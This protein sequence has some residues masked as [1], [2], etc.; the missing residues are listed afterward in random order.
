MHRFSL[1]LAAL[2]VALPVSASA[3]QSWE[4]VSTQTALQALDYAPR[5]TVVPRAAFMRVP[6]IPD[7]AAPLV[8][9]SFVEVGPDQTGVPCFNCVSGAGT[10]FNIGL[11]GPYNYVTAGA[12]GFWQYT[13]GFT[14]LKITGTSCNLAFSVAAG[15]TVLKSWSFTATGLVQFGG[16][17]YGFNET[18]AHHGA[19]V[20]VGKVTC[21]T[22][23]SSVKTPL[24]FQ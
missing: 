1:A 21:G 6:I 18:V 14:T 11:T 9:A 2:A 4:D 16:Y 8:L 13:M 7:K 17:L 24:Y 12:G 20:F 3:A 15:K 22:A 23:S 19:A 5:T 10:T